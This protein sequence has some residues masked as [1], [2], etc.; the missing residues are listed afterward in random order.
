[1]RGTSSVLICLAVA[2]AARAGAP[3]SAATA[4][5]DLSDLVDRPAHAMATGAHDGRHQAIVEQVQRRYRARVVR[6]TETTYNGRPALELRLLSEQ[7][8]WTVVVDAASGQV[9]SGDR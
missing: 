9:L 3:A 4:P 6:V 2:L 5:W 1:M 7:R 8:V